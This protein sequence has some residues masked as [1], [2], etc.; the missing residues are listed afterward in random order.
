M[1][2]E[3]FVT[4]K[5]ASAIYTNAAT[6]EYIPQDLNSGCHEHSKSRD[7]ERHHTTHQN[8][9]PSRTCHHLLRRPHTV[10]PVPARDQHT[11]LL[12]SRTFNLGNLALPIS[13]PKHDPT[14]LRPHLGIRTRGLKTSV[15]RTQTG[16]CPLYPLAAQAEDVTEEQERG[17]QRADDATMTL[18]ALH[19]QDVI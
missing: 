10:P 11:V 17:R 12:S 9:L 7:T 5:V 13:Q 14:F 8:V 6:P 2:R 16:L 4:D 3:R 15:R 18:M 19:E 1:L